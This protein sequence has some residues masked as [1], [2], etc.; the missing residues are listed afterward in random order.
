VNGASEVKHART[1]VFTKGH[2]D[3]PSVLRSG[4]NVRCEEASRPWRH[5]AAWFAAVASASCIHPCTQIAYQDTSCYLRYNFLHW[6]SWNLTRIVKKRRHKTH[7]QNVQRS[8]SERI[9][10]AALF[11]G[12]T[13]AST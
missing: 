12:K 9:G 7:P 13:G 10:S 5:K 3:R 2:E 4:Q 11:L 8:D 1:H 6:S